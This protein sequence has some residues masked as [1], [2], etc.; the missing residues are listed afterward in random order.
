MDPAEREKEAAEPLTPTEEEDARPDED[1][2]NPEW[3]T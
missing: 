2:P 3:D 1:K